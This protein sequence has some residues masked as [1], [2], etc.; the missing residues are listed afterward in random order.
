MSHTMSDREVPSARVLEA[1]ESAAWSDYFRAGSLAVL[2]L[3]GARVLCAPHV[4]SPDVNRV[5]GLGSIVRATP[6]LL[7]RTITAFPD[8]VPF[9]LQV[10]PDTDPP[11]LH[12]WIRARGFSPQ[13]RWVKLYQYLRPAADVPK[14][15]SS[16]VRVEE[17]Q[18]KDAAVLGTTLCDGFGFP[19]EMA[20]WLGAVVGRRGW[21]TYLAYRGD[22]IAGAAAMYL[23]GTAGSLVLGCALKEFRRRGVQAA[24][25]ERRIADAAAH[26]VK[27]LVTE[28]AED[29]LEKPNPSLHNLLRLGFRDAYKRE[30]YQRHI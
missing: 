8:D 21:R 9:Y 10:V 28:A 17:T 1:I 24:L 26:G 12:Q 2:D 15:A 14:T 27:L 4:H 11:E 29:I 16:E 30:N 20:S 5:I 7:E 23:E 25:I 3:N 18:A 6:E 19:P 22:S 13:R